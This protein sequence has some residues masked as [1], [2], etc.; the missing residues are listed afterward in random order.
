MD[1]PSKSKLA[2][3]LHKLAADIGPRGTGTPAEAQAASYVGEFLIGL[4]LP[5]EVH[6]FEAV[7]SQNM[8]PIAINLIA[9]LAIVLFP[10]GGAVSRWAAALLAISSAPL[11]YLTIRNATNPLAYFLPKVTSQNVEA[12]IS[13]RGEIHHRVVIL[14]HLDTNRCRLAWQSKAVQYIQP[15][16][17]LTLSMLALLGIIYSLG[18]LLE[19]LTWFWWISWLPGVYILGTLVTLWRD[20]QT[21]FSP[22]ANDNAASVAVSLVLAD[23]LSNHP[24]DHTEVWF[25]FDGAEET[26][27]RGLYDFLM[28]QGKYLREASFIGLEGIGGGELVYLTRQG[29]LFPYHPSPELLV[30]AR[31]VSDSNPD[32]NFGPA[33]MT[34]EDDVRTLRER[35]Y[36]A[37]CIAGRDPQTG[38]LPY[39]H[40]PDDTADKVE[41]EVMQQAAQILYAILGQIDQG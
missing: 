9:M 1:F 21:P 40:R 28:R 36:H 39:W 13:P 2:G 31:K 30:I 33:Q 26:D 3:H 17:F 23:H 41:P 27:H 25:V 10:L 24:L 38:A 11:L 14:A 37:I 20:E 8:F 15:L 18:A 35:G 7:S 12:T 5:V 16:T 6:R 34:M 29:V 4:D 32:L 22:G 19:T